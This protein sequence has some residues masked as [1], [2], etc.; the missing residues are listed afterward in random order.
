[1][2]TITAEQYIFDIREKE[3]FAISKAKFSYDYDILIDAYLTAYFVHDDERME[4]FVKEM[5][6]VDG[7]SRSRIESIIGYLLVHESPYCAHLTHAMQF[8]SREDIDSILI[9]QMYSLALEY[10][11]Y[12]FATDIYNK[13]IR[14]YYTNKYL[15]HTPPSVKHRF[16]D[17]Y[18]ILPESVELDE[19]YKTWKR[20]LQI[21]FR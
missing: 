4:Q 14:Q 11:H 18:P 21:R 9:I 16:S 12:V 20:L 2:D 17:I 7:I 8:L 5:G 1:M 10:K 15:T 19:D 13:F 3:E 6:G